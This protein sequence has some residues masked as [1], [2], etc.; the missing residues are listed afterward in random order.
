MYSRVLQGYVL[1]EKKPDNI[2]YFV[3][4]QKLHLPARRIVKEL[5][6]WQD[7][8]LLST[9]EGFEANRFTR[10][11]FT[12]YAVVDVDDNFFEMKESPNLDAAKT[13]K[14]A[15]EARDIRPPYI[16]PPSDY[17]LK[18]PARREGLKRVEDAPKVTEYRAALERL[19]LEQTFFLAL[20][21]NTMLWQHGY[22]LL[23]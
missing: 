18:D 23:P 19:Q 6:I 10:L 22:S 1:S 20:M 12:D 15:N 2:H 14:P 17:D 8:L 11:E 9:V 5:S 13:T 4:R 16:E 7:K 3:S 21:E